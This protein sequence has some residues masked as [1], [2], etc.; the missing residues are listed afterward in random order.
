MN[1]KKAEKCIVKIKRREEIQKFHVLF[2]G[3]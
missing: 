3:K 2:T 1:E